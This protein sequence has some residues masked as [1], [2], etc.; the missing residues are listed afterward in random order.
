[1]FGLEGDKYMRTKNDGWL[2]VMMFWYFRRQEKQKS[3][4]HKRC[5]NA[6]MIRERR[7]RLEYQKKIELIK[8]EYQRQID[9]NNAKYRRQRD[10]AYKNYWEKR[11]PIDNEYQIMRA[12]RRKQT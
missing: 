7:L 3:I 12:K 2:D 9:K 6:S 4:K 10:L 1:M 5:I 8:D 11:N